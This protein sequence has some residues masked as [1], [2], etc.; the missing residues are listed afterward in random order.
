MGLIKSKTKKQFK[1][2]K[3]VDFNKVI[4]PNDY[5]L[6]K[7]STYNANIK[8]SVNLRKRIR[9]IINY[10]DSANKN[11]NIDVLC[12]QGIRDS[13]SA[14]YLM[15]AIKKYERKNKLKFYYTPEFEEIDKSIDSNHLS[16]EHYTSS[17]ES[18]K[19]D[20]LE[21]QNIIISKYPII[22]SIF[23]ELDDDVNIDDI[24]GI[25]TVT[26]ANIQIYDNIITIYNTELTADIKSIPLI[27][28]EIR[29]K[30]LAVI[31]ND[32]SKK[33]VADTRFIIG[34]INIH[35]TTDDMVNNEFLQ[36]IQNWQ[37]VDIYRHLNSNDSGFTNSFNERLEYI[38]FIMSK[39][40]NDE[41]TKYNKKF[42]SI[43]TSDDMIKFLFKFYK[44]YFIDSTVI[45]NIS[46][47]SSATSYAIE[48]VFMFP[49][50]K[51]DT[52]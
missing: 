51:I 20:T 46:K 23:A 41:N 28:S 14:Y 10:L 4:I 3:I 48:C 35:E 6:I 17:K 21:T 49:K 43:K 47:E 13:Y 29:E 45:H 34:S 38:L 32:I 27:N 30:E 9:E 31:F 11:K 12:L 18:K 22:S 16:I 50:K 37:C 2:T 1:D 8:N 36:L 5:I 19:N 7:I 39:H 24:L 42:K 26:G 44:I 52:S 40:I 33:C 25:K 15:S